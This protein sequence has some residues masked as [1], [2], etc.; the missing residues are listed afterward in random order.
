[1]VK[2]KKK[3]K[4]SDIDPDT[5]KVYTKAKFKKVTAAQVAENEITEVVPGTPVVKSPAE[6]LTERVAQ[7]KEELKV[8]QLDATSKLMA[9]IELK[10]IEGASAYIDSSQYIQDEVEKANLLII[11]TIMN[12][13]EKSGAR[14]SMMFGCNA[15][16][17]ALVALSST[18][19][20]QKNSIELIAR[21]GLTE[22]VID[23]VL[24]HVGSPAYFNVTHNVIMKAVPFNIE[25]LKLA[26]ND[27]SI[28]LQLVDPDLTNVTEEKFTERF[29]RRAVIAENMAR[30][31]VELANSM[32]NVYSVT[33]EDLTGK[34]PEDNDTAA[35]DG[36]SDEVVDS[37]GDKEATVN[38]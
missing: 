8:K 29:D 2:L 22:R 24:L 10:K 26:I 35:V 20:Y 1:M 21:Y 38:E 18:L 19:R 17:N 13:L 31:A 16:V 30:D 4:M 11:G 32:V 6:L 3:I 33:G 12:E 25:K 23:A 9:Q 37:A 27:I 5:G 7:A 28:K 14:I 34:E 15:T 36:T